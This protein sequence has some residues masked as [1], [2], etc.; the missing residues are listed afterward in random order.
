MKYDF[1]ILGGAGMQ[2]KIVAKDLLS[3]KHSVF[4]ADLYKNGLENF[5]KNKNVGFDFIDLRNIKKTIKLI[6]KIDPEVIINCA[7]GDWNVNVYKAALKAKKHVIDLGSEIPMTEEQIKMDPLFKK[8]GLVAITGCGST[9]GVNNILLHYAH[10]LLDSLNTVEAGFAWD[11]NIKKFV[12]PFSIQSIIEEFTDP[13]P[14]IENGKWIK[15]VPLLNIEKRKF[16]KIGEQDCFFVRHP[17]TFTFDYYNKKD[18]LKNV[19]FYAGFPKHSSD[20]IRSFIDAGLGSKKEV[21]IEGKKM[22]PIDMLSQSL[23]GL[24]YPKGYKE[25]ENLW[26]NVWGKKMERKSKLQWN[27]L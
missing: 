1:L 12:V 7:E 11:S 27:A 18:G 3:N 17:E 13:A 26:V 19:R 24:G 20:V 15:K 22:K 9:P 10:L 5:L 25:W 16:R 4:L 23:R 8:A 6:K 14:I 2:G 21:E